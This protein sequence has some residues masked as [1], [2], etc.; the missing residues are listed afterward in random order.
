MPKSA[1]RSAATAAVPTDAFAS[2]ASAAGDDT[3]GKPK[4]STAVAA[5]KAATKQRDITAMFPKLPKR[6]QAPTPAGPMVLVGIIDHTEE[7][8][9]YLA[10][11]K[12]S[13]SADWYDAFLRE[14][15]QKYFIDIKKKL[16]AEIASGK[17]VY[18]PLAEIYTFTK[19]P[20]KDVRV[21]ILGQDPYHGPNQAHGLCFSVKKGVSVPPSLVN[22][23]KELKADLGDDFTIP[24]SGDLQGWCDQGVLLLNAAL[25]VRASEPNSHVTWGWNKF[26]DAIVSHIARESENVVFM[27]WGAFAHKKGAKI[28]TS[29]HLVLKTVHPSPLSVYRGFFGCKHFSQANEYLKDKGRDVVDWNALK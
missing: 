21:V 13:M 12:E 9:K 19:C 28:D 17:T 22:I 3:T 29:R 10:L 8:E 2:G 4:G 16:E 1:P 11:E 23:Y 15:S 20:I 25:T 14:M 7:E 27:L 5:K 6:Q 18:P 26:T 24:S